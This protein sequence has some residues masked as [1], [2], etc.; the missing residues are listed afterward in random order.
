MNGQEAAGRLQIFENRM[1]EATPCAPRRRF[2]LEVVR[3]TTN[4]TTFQG[5][6]LRQQ[7]RGSKTEFCVPEVK[8]KE[9]ASPSGGEGGSQVGEAELQL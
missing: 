1:Q 4:A 8:Q 6:G 2:P 3:T 7:R 5:A 9:A